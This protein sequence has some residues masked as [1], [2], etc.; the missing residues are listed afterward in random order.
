M[1]FPSNSLTAHGRQTQR[2]RTSSQRP[3]S[4]PPTHHTQLWSLSP[5]GRQP[6]RQLLSR[7]CPPTWHPSW[8]RQRSL[9][10]SPPRTRTSSRPPFTRAWSR[11]TSSRRA[12]PRPKPSRWTKCNSQPTSPSG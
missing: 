7:A 3:S 2:A 5:L 4:P 12:A 8:H 6:C 11:P 1:R 9:S 10:S